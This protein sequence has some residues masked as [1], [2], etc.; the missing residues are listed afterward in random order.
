MTKFSNAK[1][2]FLFS[3]TLFT[4]Q[5]IS[6]SGLAQEMLYLPDTVPLEHHR[7]PAVDLIYKG[8]PVTP[9]ELVLLRDKQKVD[10]SELMPDDTS[11]LWKNNVGRKLS[12]DEDKLEIDLSRPLQYIERS[13]EMSGRFKFS[14]S[15]IGKDGQPKVFRL[16]AGKDA[17]SILIRKNLLRKLGY[18]VPPVMYIPKISLNFKGTITVKDFID[19]LEKR[20]FGNKDRWITNKID[21]TTTTLEMQDLVAYADN[22]S[23]Y[24]LSQG[25]LPESII[26]G[27]RIFNSLI[28]PYS[29]VSIDETINGFGWTPGRIQNNFVFLPS[30]L[31]RALLD[32]RRFSTPLDDAQWMLKLMNKLTRQDFEEI[33]KLSY[34]P[35][36]V[37]TLLVEKIISRRKW[38]YENFKIPN[39]TPIE[40]NDKIS[41]GQYLVNGELKKE[42]WEG[43]AA[44]YAYSD[45]ESPLSGP[46]IRAF[47]QSKTSSTL[48][49]TLVT[50]FDNALFKGTDIE[51]KVFQKQ[52]EASKEQFIHFL[53]T[54]ELKKVPFGLFPIPTIDGYVWAS[55]DVVMG[56]YLGTDNVIQLA[57]TFEMAIMPGV[58][59]SALG[60]PEFTAFQAGV[61]LKASRS[62]THLRSIKSIKRALKEPF[63]NLLV[64]LL[65]KETG[66]IFD[67]ILSE[68]Y[69]SLQAEEKEKKL[70]EIMAT[71]KE[72]MGTGDAF[73][74]SN[75]LSTDVFAGLGYALSDNVK[76]Q[77]TLYGTKRSIGRLQI[78]KRSDNEIQVYKDSGDINV[79]GFNMGLKARIPIITLDF[80]KSKGAT[81][82]QFYSLDLTPQ[83]KPN[84]DIEKTLIGLRQLL[85]DNSLELITA[86]IK[87]Y[88]VTHQFT[89]KTQSIGVLMQ[90][91][92]GQKSTDYI[93]ITHPKGQV[94]TYIRATEGLREG[95]DYQGLT[96]DAINALLADY[97]GNEDVSVPN[98]GSGNPGDTFLGK[99]SSR[100]AI[101]DAE[102]ITNNGTKTLVEPIMNV[103]YKWKGWKIKTNKMIDLVNTVNSKFN[104]ELFST[105]EFGRA[106]NFQLYAIDVSMYLYQEALATIL[107]LSNDDIRKIIQSEA[108]IDNYPYKTTNAGEITQ[109]EL[110]AQLK[111]TIADELIRHKKKFHEKYGTDDKKGALEHGVTFVSTLELLLP[112]NRFVQLVGGDKNIFVIGRLTAFRDTDE[113]GDEPIISN[114]R[115][116]IGSER[117]RGGLAQAQQSMGITGS[118]LYLNWILRN[119]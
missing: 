3:L 27:R 86:N 95:V 5:F 94:N 104:Y 28:I 47:F 15:Q 30:P 21:D 89:E 62:Y 81:K 106:D 79:I 58:F 55:R 67:E 10:L 97:N 19:N 61:Q 56:E 99:S 52:F 80:N 78:I 54:G 113:K 23:F 107:N 53:K 12:E 24:N 8:K 98:K 1:F 25:F 74:I 17:H 42:N 75:N 60:M 29:L 117:P 41:L 105:L 49:N 92:F 34:F 26:S 93:G 70:S 101:M 33:V 46:E 13:P 84:P 66:L 39:Y 108:I 45:L 2:Q 115:G 119:L 71:F 43:H 69:Q 59:I 87:P 88:L 85:I 118:S 11:E 76:L 35:E 20:A 91:R 114:S 51:K 96:V 50:K 82:T 83:Y 16:L 110:D 65:K 77:A 112:F 64:M 100:N 36:D 4:A 57:D 72:A 73:V 103:A 18:N 38:L 44:R 63:K 40:F 9:D 7:R 90:K 111:K 6:S 31:P 68:N 116:Q 32:Q 48:L 109:Q 37:G 102:I 22:E 14:V